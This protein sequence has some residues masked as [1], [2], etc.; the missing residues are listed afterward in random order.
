[1]TAS[2][3]SGGPEHLLKGHLPWPGSACLPSPG[4]A[5]LRPDGPSL[6]LISL[7]W[8]RLASASPHLEQSLLARTSP[9]WS[10]S[11]SAQQPRQISAN[12]GAPAT[13]RL[14]KAMHLFMTELIRPRQREKKMVAPLKTHQSPRKLPVKLRTPTPQPAHRPHQFSET[15]EPV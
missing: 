8:P 3:T 5:S 9:P 13:R 10:G 7:H 14:I 4:S 11:A 12:S 6:A 15:R 2:R 1:M